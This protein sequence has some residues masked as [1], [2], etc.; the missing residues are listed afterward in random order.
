MKITWYHLYAG[1]KSKSNKWTGQT[2]TQGHGQWTSGYQRVG[3]GE[4]GEK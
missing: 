4:G 3:D 2:E 1:Y